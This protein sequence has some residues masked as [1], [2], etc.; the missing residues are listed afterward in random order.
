MA[1]VAEVFGHPLFYVAFWLLWL[2][3]FGLSLV[4]AGRWLGGHLRAIRL[5]L[6]CIYQELRKR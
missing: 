5:N 4:M 2:L 1:L 3:A 6:D